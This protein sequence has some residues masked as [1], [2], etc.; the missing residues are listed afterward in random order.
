MSATPP[1]L[2]TALPVPSVWG[3]VS[4][5]VT[6]PQN[7]TGAKVASAGRL[8][9]RLNWYLQQ[10]GTFQRLRRRGYP[11]TSALLLSD[12]TPEAVQ[13]FP[14]ELT[15]RIFFFPAGGITKN[16]MVT[17]ASLADPRGEFSVVAAGDFCVPDG[18]LLLIQ[19][20]FEFSRKHA[21]AEL[22]VIGSGWQDERV[23][24]LMREL[25]LGSHIELWDWMPRADLQEKLK[26]THVFIAPDFNA[27]T[28]SLCVD[29]MAAG[30]PVVAYRGSGAHVFVEEDWGIE[31]PW[32]TPQQIVSDLKES[33]DR[34][35]SSDGLRRRMGRAALRNV[36]ENLAWER[37][38]KNLESVYSQTLLQGESIRVARIGGSRFFY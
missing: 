24:R 10:S 36:R 38:G 35:A 2:S 7:G 21:G 34:L 37:Q 28:S 27:D 9:R 33:L 17:T 15:D 14:Q 12:R 25:S 32:R 31:I 29:A 23:G 30:V 22:A 18:Y 5:G 13:S 8:G 11:K 19:A 1:L 26:R 6:S 20:F 16:R 3:P 4:P